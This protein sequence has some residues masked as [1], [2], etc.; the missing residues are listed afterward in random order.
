MLVEEAKKL[1]ARVAR[2]EI[3]QLERR[4]LESFAGMHRDLFTKTM[5][6]A[7]DDG[8]V[9]ERPVFILP[10][11]QDEIIETLRAA[12]RIPKSK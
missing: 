2:G 7:S 8:I 5:P 6:V 9:R 4:E 12:G 1:K 10:F 11:S 3:G